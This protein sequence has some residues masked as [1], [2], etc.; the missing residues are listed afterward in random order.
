MILQSNNTLVIVQYI[1]TQLKNEIKYLL[2]NVIEIFSVYF[3]FGI[4]Y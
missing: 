2:L 4:K 3:Y 1:Q